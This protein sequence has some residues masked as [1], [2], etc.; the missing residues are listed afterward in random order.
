MKLNK[1]QQPYSVEALMWDTL[2][3]LRSDFHTQL[4]PHLAALLKHYCEN[5]DLPGLRDLSFDEHWDTDPYTFKCVYQLIT[6]FK[7]VIFERSDRPFGQLVADASSAF[8]A[9][10]NRLRALPLSVPKHFGPAISRARGICFDILGIWDYEEHLSL[11][12]MGRHAAVG[13]PLRRA[14]LD[15]KWMPSLSGSSCHIDWF[16]SSYL[17]YHRPAREHFNRVHLAGPIGSLCDTL[18]MTFVPKSFKSVRAISPNTVIGSLYTDGIGRMITRRLKAA[19][20]DISSLQATHRDLARLASLNGELATC[21]QSSASDNITS[22]LVELLLPRDWVDAL[23]LG[24]IDRV[25]LPSGAETHLESFCTMGI[26]YTFPLQT[27]IFYALAKGIDY[28]FN[29]ERGLVSCYGDDLIFPSANMPFFERL[30]SHLGLVINADKSFSSGG[31]R[32]SCGGDYYRGMDV[33]PFQ[34]KWVSSDCC[35]KTQILALSYYLFNGFRRRWDDTDISS[36]LLILKAYIRSLSGQRVHICP[37]DFSEN[38]GVLVNSLIEANNLGFD[39][40]HLRRNRNGA[41]IF[42]YLRSSTK[43]QR[44]VYP[45]PF[46]WKSL[47]D[48]SCPVDMMDVVDVPPPIRWKY[49]A[50]VALPFSVLPGEGKVNS[51]R[52]VTVL[53]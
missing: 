51:H 32:E 45:D 4:P 37:R 48:P 39:T 15:A 24:R 41:L 52:S 20:L 42:C 28:Q 6:L 11:C 13:V 18:R 34:P 7:R 31:F 17:G 2:N 19:G 35:D 26:G 1:Q 29:A 38:S 40:S 27:L 21:D 44:I 33:R 30:C 9:N 8:V 36:T 23:S 14:S 25:T 3:A 47:Q 22:R 5:R 12:R 16:N 46:Y 53:L 49:K 50:G 43:E 10:Q